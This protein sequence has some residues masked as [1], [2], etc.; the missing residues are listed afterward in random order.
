MGIKT[1]ELSW[2]LSAICYREQKLSRP[3]SQIRRL[4]SSTQKRNQRCIKRIDK[5]KKIPSRRRPHLLST[6]S[7]QSRNRINSPNGQSDILSI[8]AQT[9]QTP[10][11][12]PTRSLLHRHRIRMD[13]SRIPTTR[14]P[15]R[16]RSKLVPQPQRR[17]LLRPQNRHHPPRQPRQ[18]TPNSNHPTRLPTPPTLQP[19]IPISLRIINN[20]NNNNINNNPNPNPHP[21]PPRH[22]R[23]NRTLHGPAYRTLRREMA[24]LA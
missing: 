3:T 24:P 17:R 15:R 13:Q 21:H 9:P 7:S 18:R 1:N 12:Y 5:S 10:T 22:P 23:L 19:P 11:Q 4:Q 20:N 6:R 2:T 16:I 8:L 14:S